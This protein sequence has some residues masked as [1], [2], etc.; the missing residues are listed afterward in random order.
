MWSC[1]IEFAG[2]RFCKPAHV[3]CKFNASS[4]HA[5]ANT[6]IWHLLLAGVTYRLQHAFDAALAKSTRNQNA[7]V[8]LKLLCAGAL[9]FFQALGFNPVHMQFQIVGESAVHQRFFQRLVGIFVLDVFTD[10]GD[11]HVSLRVV[12]P[13]HQLFPLFQVLIFRF[14]V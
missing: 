4:L 14:Q 13:M 8:V 5:Q 9:S 1:G 7:I 6:E 12:Y 2:V 10:N 11:S 3:T